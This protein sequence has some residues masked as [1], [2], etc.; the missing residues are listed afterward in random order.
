VLGVAE[1]VVVDSGASE[2]SVWEN[3]IVALKAE[4]DGFVSRVVSVIGGWALT[5][6]GGGISGA[7]SSGLFA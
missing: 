2:G 4:L 3:G 1:E 5:L 7:G 6:S